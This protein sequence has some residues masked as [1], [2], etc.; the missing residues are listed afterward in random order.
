MILKQG[1]I[2][3]TTHGSY[4]DYSQHG[5]WRALKTFNMLEEA[6]TSLGLPSPEFPKSW[7]D[8][9][10]QSL[11]SRGL[12]E[13]IKLPEFWL[14][15]FSAPKDLENQ[16]RYIDIDSKVRSFVDVC[17]E[18]ED[19]REHPEVGVLCESKCIRS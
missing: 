8:E 12:V 14:G 17:V 16:W 5:A 4:A 7:D 10:M 3:L 18:H 15:D 1:V 19:C 6:K 2:F 9:F 13:N 11:V